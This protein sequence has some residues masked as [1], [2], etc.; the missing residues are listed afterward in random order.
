ERGLVRA[1]FG[2][3][4]ASRPCRNRAADASGGAADRGSPRR[5]QRRGQP[6]SNG[7]AGQEGLAILI[8]G[9]GSERSLTPG[10][11]QLALAIPEAR[12][13]VL[14]ARFAESM[15]DWSHA[16]SA[17][18]FALSRTAEIETE[19]RLVDLTRAAALAGLSRF[20]EPHGERA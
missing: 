10:L 13:A 14:D 17:F 9:A 4:A 16:H 7:R 19:A 2:G 6:R 11:V 20:G 1:V 12:H 8:P 3:Q 18:Q 5:R 15:G